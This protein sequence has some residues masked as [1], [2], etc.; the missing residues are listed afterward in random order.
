MTRCTAGVRLT[1]AF[2]VSFLHFNSC[3]EWVNI[4][5]TLYYTILYTSPPT[6]FLVE[7]AS[8]IW[9][10]HASDECK[11]IIQWYLLLPILTVIQ[12]VTNGH[13]LAECFA[14]GF[15]T[16]DYPLYHSTLQ[17]YFAQWCL[18][19]KMRTIVFLFAPRS[20]FPQFLPR[21]LLKTTQQ[22]FNLPSHWE[23][24]VSWVKN[25]PIKQDAGI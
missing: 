1:S 7:H 8:R 20:E 11:R 22:V 5:M 21:P 2:F 3:V 9:M 4:S 10:T 17:L 14:A 23:C 12:G 15:R 16:S 19:P 25:W 18:H 13:C 6:F 24:L